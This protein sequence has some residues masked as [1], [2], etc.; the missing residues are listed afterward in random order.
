MWHPIQAMVGFRNVGAFRPLNPTIFTK[1][2]TP[3]NAAWSREAW[4]RSKNLVLV[5]DFACFPLLVL[6]MVHPDDLNSFRKHQNNKLLLWLQVSSLFFFTWVFHCRPSGTKKIVP[7]CSFLTHCHLSGFSVR[8]EPQFDTCDAGF[9]VLNENEKETPK[10][11]SLW[12]VCVDKTSEWQT[13][14]HDPWVESEDVTRIWSS[15]M[16]NHNAWTHVWPTFQSKKWWKD[17]KFTA[18]IDV[19]HAEGRHCWIHHDV[20]AEEALAS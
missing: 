14:E 6:C 5:L 12:F 19:T 4:A 11:D 7:Q 2:R 1:L 20:F 3:P 9:V 16:Q 17:K 15:S 10:C 18:I 8:W 13:F